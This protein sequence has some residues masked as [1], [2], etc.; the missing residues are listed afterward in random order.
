METGLHGPPPSVTETPAST[1]RRPEERPLLTARCRVGG[2]PGV[3]HRLRLY[4]DRLVLT[5]WRVRGRFR[6]EIP[7]EGLLRVEHWPAG[8]TA[9]LVLVLRG[10]ELA[11]EMRRGAC[12]WRHTLRSLQATPASA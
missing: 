10:R 9:T 8:A 3:W 5:G 11:V 7:L 6:Y 2:M 12:L 1:S 4:G